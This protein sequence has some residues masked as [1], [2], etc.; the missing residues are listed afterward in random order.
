MKKSNLIQH[1]QVK[2]KKTKKWTEKIW[3]KFCSWEKNQQQ[4]RKVPGSS[5]SNDDDDDNNKN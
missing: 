2:S 1:F 4:Q 3:R 5:S